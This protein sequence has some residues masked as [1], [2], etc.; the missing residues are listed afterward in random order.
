MWT[1]AGSSSL[2]ICEV[3]AVMH[4]KG[5]PSTHVGHDLIADEMVTIVD[6]R[7]IAG[8]G[9]QNVATGA[10][11]QLLPSHVL[12]AYTHLRT[13]RAFRSNSSTSVGAEMYCPCSYLPMR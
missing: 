11:D 1:V 6:P 3:C 10:R 8:I 7:L 12:A 5:H 9:I 2:I 13:R 4:W